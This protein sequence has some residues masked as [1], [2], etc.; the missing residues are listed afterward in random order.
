MD[1]KLKQTIIDVLKDNLTILIYTNKECDGVETL[2][3]DLEFD[4]KV[5]AT[6]T[7]YAD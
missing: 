7:C 5:F 4:N 3:V 2:N 1:D 6:S